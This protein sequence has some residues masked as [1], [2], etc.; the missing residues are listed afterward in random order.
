MIKM[1]CKRV[2]TRFRKQYTAVLDE[3]KKKPYM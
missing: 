1:L 3:C 2:I